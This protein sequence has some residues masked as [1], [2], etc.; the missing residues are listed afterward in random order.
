MVIQSSRAL[1]K[2][3]CRQDEAFEYSITMQSISSR[4]TTH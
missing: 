3:H 1:A 4:A 2:M